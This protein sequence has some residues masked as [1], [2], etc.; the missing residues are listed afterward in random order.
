L[1]MEE[2][3]ISDSEYESYYPRLNGLRT[4]IVRYLPMKPSM[5]ILDLATGYGY[6]AIEVARHNTTVKTT[7]IDI[8][9][10]CVQKSQRNI[11]QVDLQNLISI[12]RMDATDMGFHHEVF[13]MAVN[14]TGLED[15]HMT[16]GK[17]GLQQ[18]FNEVYRVLAPE[19]HFCFVVMPPEEM[20]TEAQR[21]E[22]AL[23]SYI[24]DAIW[25][26]TNEYETLLERAGFTVCST[27]R[28]YTGLK[29]TP[30][31]AKTEIRFACDYAPKIYGVNTPSYEEIWA[32]FGQ[33][34]EKHGLGHYSKVVLMIAQRGKATT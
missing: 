11:E 4:R 2:Q 7:G 8:S 13:D 3:Y 19:S 1:K 17:A 6:F 34:I 5:R 16:R 18:T 30:E 14:F 33:D 28:Y 12:V 25:L 20:E 23:F 21:I 24:C 26:T 22:V 32:R 27:Y 9:L 15:I 31:Q 29:L 10:S